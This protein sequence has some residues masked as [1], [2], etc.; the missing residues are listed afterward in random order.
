MCCLPLNHNSILCCN[1][2][3][4][5]P[6]LDIVL[7]RGCRWAQMDLL[8]FYFIV[9]Y[10]SFIENALNENI[11]RTC[12]LGTGFLVLCLPRSYLPN[13]SSHSSLLNI[14]GKHLIFCQF[15]PSFKFKGNF[16]IWKN[17]GKNSMG[18]GEE[19]KKGRGGKYGLVLCFSGGHFIMEDGPTP[20]RKSDIE[21]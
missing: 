13:W 12:P 3:P 8:C 20:A 7:W 17:T 10:L 16:G 14:Y 4:L 1:F 5:L 9:N 11:M 21:W 6:E 19:K 15:H 2:L 18:K